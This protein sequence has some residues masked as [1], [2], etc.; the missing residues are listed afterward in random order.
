MKRLNN[1]VFSNVNR[2]DQ[3]SQRTK[4]DE[5]S[6]KKNDNWKI[7]FHILINA[8]TFRRKN[9]QMHCLNKI[10]M[11]FMQIILNMAKILNWYVE[12]IDDLNWFETL[13]NILNF[14]SIV[15]ELNLQNINF[16]IFLNFYKCQ[17]IFVKMEF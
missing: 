11:I 7:I 15:I 8:S 16:M 14:A 9:I 3:S 17:Y 10:M 12:K 2:N 13:K 6:D 4:I 1:D 5:N